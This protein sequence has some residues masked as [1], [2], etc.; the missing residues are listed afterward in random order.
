M[1][2]FAGLDRR[3]ALRAG[4]SRWRAQAH[5]AELVLRS[6]RWLSFSGFR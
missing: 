5:Y 1:T 2:C 6:K 3:P 4:V